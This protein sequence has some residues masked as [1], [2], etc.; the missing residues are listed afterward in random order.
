VREPRPAM[1]AR[2]LHGAIGLPGELGSE[3]DGHT[4]RGVH[5]H[6]D[7]GLRL[8]RCRHEKRKPWSGASRRARRRQRSGMRVHRLYVGCCDGKQKSDEELS[9]ASSRFC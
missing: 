9:H 1:S 5:K 6:V 3:M 4:G 7:K 8:R 2:E